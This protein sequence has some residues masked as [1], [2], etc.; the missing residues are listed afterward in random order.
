MRNQL[1]L[2]EVPSAKTL[3]NLY[4]DRSG[5]YGNDQWLVW[6]NLFVLQKKTLALFDQLQQAREKHQYLGE[7]HFTDLPRTWAE[8]GG[9]KP[10]TTYDWL[11]VCRINFLSDNFYFNVLAVDTHSPQ[12]NHDAFSKPFHAYNRFSRMAITSGIVWFYKA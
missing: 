2:F 3:V 5:S 1:T 10:K 7:L 11:E 4:Q 9:K 8:P 12:F 6:G